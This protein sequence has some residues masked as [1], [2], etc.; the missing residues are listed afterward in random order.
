MKIRTKP[1]TKTVGEPFNTEYVYDENI[2]S[3]KTE[4]VTPGKNG[5]VTITTSYDKD[6]KKV[7]TFETE[8]AGQNRIVKIGSKT[9]GT[10]KVK[11]EIP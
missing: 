7:V 1:V 6:Q 10:E 8:E 2:E 11:E 3:G 9:N 5:K 4:E